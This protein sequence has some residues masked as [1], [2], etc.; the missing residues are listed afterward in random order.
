MFFTE[1]YAGS[2]PLAG[3]E[4][5]ARWDTLY[6][7]LVWI[8]VIFFIAVIG[9]MVYFVWKYS[10]RS[11]LKP[12][13]ITGNHLLEAA[14]VVGPTLLLL[15]IFGWGYSVYHQMTAAPTDAYEIRVIAKQWLWQFQYDNGRTTTAELYVP[16]NRPVKLIMTSQ[17]VLHSFFV[18]NFRIKQDVVPGMYTSIW[19]EAKVPGR[20]QVF[21]AEYCGTSH[22]GM[23][24]QVIVLDD[25]QWKAWNAGKKLPPIPDARE[26]ADNDTTSA[27]RKTA[28]VAADSVSGSQAAPAAAAQLTMAQ[29]GKNLFE[30]KGCTSCHGINGEQKTGPSLVGIYGQEVEFA[31]GQR[32]VRDENY[33]HESIVKPNAK[34]VRGYQALMPTYQGQL[35][36]LEM[37]SIIAY[38]KS[39]K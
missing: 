38:I 34:I 8:S 11:G 28:D 18:P 23:L 9:A 37:N 15:M 33:L 27:D 12:K 36:A 35:T 2:L 20:H 5:A 19:F 25:D 14:F 1:A 32:L 6:L 7:F 16:L 31:N 26:L 29:Q 4:V 13:Y 39:L 3:T 22:S 24:A 10:H 17:D 30:V 21:C